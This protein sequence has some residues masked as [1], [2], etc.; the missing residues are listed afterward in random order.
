MLLPPAIRV[1][2]DANVEDH[3]DVIDD[4]T[5]MVEVTIIGIRKSA[6]NVF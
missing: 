2:S 4:A 6:L 3:I 1:L 5:A